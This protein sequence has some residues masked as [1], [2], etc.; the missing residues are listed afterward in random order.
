MYY[1]GVC[2][3]SDKEEEGMKERGKGW[4]GRLRRNVCICMY[5]RMVFK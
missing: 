1:V 2:A 5:E 4:E 3:R